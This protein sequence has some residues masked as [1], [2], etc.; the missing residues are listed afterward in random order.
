MS[1]PR[2]FRFLCGEN[3]LAGTSGIQRHWPVA[4]DFLRDICPA[5]W[6]LQAEAPPKGEVQA[7]GAHRPRGTGVS[8]QVPQLLQAQPQPGDPG[9]HGEGLQPHVGGPGGL[10]P[11]VLRQGVQHAGGEARGAVPLQVP[12]LL[13]RRV[14]ELCHNGGHPHL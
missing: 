7:A 14:Q 11:A 3:L 8:E 12:L 1:M 2:R 9:H 6:T 5:G 4:E 13:L 10:Q